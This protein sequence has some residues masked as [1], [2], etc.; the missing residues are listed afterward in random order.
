MKLLT[1][2]MLASNVKGIHKR[3]PLG[4]RV[5][6]VETEENEYNED[7]I[8]K[9]LKRIDYSA[10]HTAAADVTTYTV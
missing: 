9:M 10:L 1:H 3:Y 7:F 2:N 8:K 4:L 6:E 5:S